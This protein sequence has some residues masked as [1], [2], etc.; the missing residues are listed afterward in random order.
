MA[1]RDVVYGLRGADR[2]PYA[3]IHPADDL[4][5]LFRKE[6]WPGVVWDRELFE[7]GALGR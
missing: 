3:S 4:N 6:C 2:W 5:K 1:H 7:A